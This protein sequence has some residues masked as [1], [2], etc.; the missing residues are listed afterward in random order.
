M[1][2]STLPSTHVG[3]TAEELAKRARIRELRAEIAT[4]ARYRTAM[5]RAFR[6]PHRS[7]EWAAAVNA[8]GALLTGYSPDHTWADRRHNRDV[9]T[10]RHVALATLRGKQHLA[11]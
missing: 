3:P 9:L 7:A 6:L 5:N 11:G 10:T 8:A 1:S 2:T 4:L